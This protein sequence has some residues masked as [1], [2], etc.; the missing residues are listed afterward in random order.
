VAG[1]T[2]GIDPPTP[3]TSSRPTGT[4]VVEGSTAPARRPP[5]RGSAVLVPLV[6]AVTALV[7]F[8]LMTA[9]SEPPLRWQRVRPPPGPFNSSS[10]VATPE[11]FVALSPPTS[12]G[13][14]VW[15]SEDGIDWR[16][17]RVT[18]SPS[19][20][21]PQGDGLI[22]FHDY[23]GV[24][25]APRPGGWEEIRE[26]SFPDLVRV[27]Y[28]SGR[29][30]VLATELGLL[31]QT[32]AGDLLWSVDGARFEQVIAAPRWGAATGMS[33]GDGCF[34]T[35]EGSIDVAPLVSTDQGFVALVSAG[36]RD[37]VGVWPVCRPE[38]WESVD[39]IGWKRSTVGSPFGSGAFVYD[40]AWRDGVFLAVGGRGFAD[41]AMWRS[42]DGLAWE[43][44]TDPPASR[45]YELREV[46][47][48]RLG[49]IVLGELADRPGLVG[50]ASP[51]ARCWEPFP[52]HVEGTIAA[53]TAERMLVI[54]RRPPV[55]SWLGLAAD[56]GLRC[57]G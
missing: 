30:G 29:A 25:L 6:L 20:L 42:T 5:P 18:G 34:P 51:D 26:M 9:P 8:S 47:A 55:E 3:P 40:L 31:A 15:S 24:R 56:G 23:G 39:G 19:H 1:L 32:V 35:T 41:P 16:S 57:G 36:A 45:R 7:A 43:E 54:D 22:A 48:G 28:G 4:V 12:G 37:P 14:L 53:V 27:G 52:A 17:D 38:V 10:L 49:W 33:I 13:V 21:T 46:E 2:P 44:L 11:R 50:W